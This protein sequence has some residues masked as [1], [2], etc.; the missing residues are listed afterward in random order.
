MPDTDYILEPASVQYGD[1]VGTAAADEHITMGHGNLDA[2]V[3]LDSDRWWIVAIDISDEDSFY[4]YAIDREA[5]GIA[6]HAGL[7]AYA[8]REGSVPVTSY[9]VHETSPA[10]LIQLMTMFH[11]Q[12][13]SRSLEGVPLRVRFLDDLRYHDEDA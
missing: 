4:V 13:R 2:L 11:I 3:N 7:Q 8:A 9:L 12:L 1:W 10:R 6:D 5:T